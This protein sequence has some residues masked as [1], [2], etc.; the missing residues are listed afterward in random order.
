MSVLLKRVLTFKSNIGFGDF[1]DFTV[2]Q[3]I[4]V[5]KEYEL[6]KMYY[7]LDRIDFRQDVKDRLFITKE[8]EI[9]K[10]SKDYTMRKKHAFA[11]VQDLIDFRENR[12]LSNIGRAFNIANGKAIANQNA[13]AFRREGSK[14]NMTLK[15]Q[16]K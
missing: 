12:G 8:R 1:K 6:V 13:S 7:N 3:V 2:Q 11:I 14:A 4:D 15:N 9:V 5:G 10:P 16:G